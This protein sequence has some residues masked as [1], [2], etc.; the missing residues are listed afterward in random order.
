MSPDRLEAFSLTAERT[1]APVPAPDTDAVDVPATVLR[2]VLSVLGRDTG[3]RSA[4][5]RAAAR[6]T[7]AALAATRTESV[8]LPRVTVRLIA[9]A[10]DPLTTLD[11]DERDPATFGHPAWRATIALDVLAV[12]PSEDAEIPAAS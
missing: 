11:L 7:I 9:A 2:T 3:A 5:L 10:T 12:D 8:A 4:A 6:E 1:T